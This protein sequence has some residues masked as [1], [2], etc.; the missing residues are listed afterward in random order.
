MGKS[1]N[2]TYIL[3]CGNCGCENKRSYLPE[4][5]RCVNCGEGFWVEEY[6]EEKA[7]P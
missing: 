2:M 4:K 6:R 1:E 5:A 7:K 3:T